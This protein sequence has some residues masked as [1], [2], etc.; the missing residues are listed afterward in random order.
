MGLLKAWGSV[1]DQSIIF[2]NESFSHVLVEMWSLTDW[3]LTYFEINRTIIVRVELCEDLVHKHGGLRY[4]QDRWVHVHHLRFIE[5]SSWVVLYEPSAQVLISNSV[6]GVKLT[7]ATLISPLR[8][9]LSSPPETPGPP[10]PAL[11]LV[12][13]SCEIF[14]FSSY[15]CC[16]TSNRKVVTKS[17]QYYDGLGTAFPLPIVRSGVLSNLLF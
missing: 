8:W 12:C 3:G 15:F 17:L 6:E 9:I 4:W 1:V 7:S 14:S 11:F 16:K 10:V 2:P 5:S 13:C